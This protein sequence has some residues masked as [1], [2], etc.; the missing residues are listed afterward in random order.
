[1][2]YFINRERRGSRADSRILITQPVMAWPGE[3]RQGMARHGRAGQGMA[4]H[5]GAGLRPR[6]NAPLLIL[7]SGQGSIFLLLI[8]LDIK[9]HL[10]KAFLLFT[11]LTEA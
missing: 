11:M 3:A 7:I 4:R 1:M 9:K 8:F 6:P 10:T 2:F 5:G